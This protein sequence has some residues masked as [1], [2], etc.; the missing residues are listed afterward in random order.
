MKG[1]SGSSLTQLLTMHF[2]HVYVFLQSIFTLYL[3]TVAIPSVS[4]DLYRR[5][6]PASPPT[7]FWYPLNPI[8]RWTSPHRP[9]T[10]N[11]PDIFIERSISLDDTPSPTISPP[12][13]SSGPKLGSPTQ[14]S[15]PATYHVD[16]IQPSITSRSPSTPLDDLYQPGKSTTTGISVFWLALAV[17]LGAAGTHVFSKLS[18]ATRRRDERADNGNAAWWPQVLSALTVND[19]NLDAEAQPLSQGDLFGTWD[20][21]QESEVLPRYMVP[22]ALAAT[23]AS[24]PQN[25]IKTRCFGRRQDVRSISDWDFTATVDK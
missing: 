9:S 22:A 5:A 25:G 16:I 14:T 19:S 3:I 13:I 18:H 20:Q 21:P 1:R 15:Q 23:P 10:D 4:L 8:E 17:L 7:S 24:S 12:T 6:S 2:H 11:H